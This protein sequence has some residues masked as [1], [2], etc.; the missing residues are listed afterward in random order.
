M[1]TIQKYGDHKSPFKVL[2]GRI[3]YT[4][5]LIEE[6]KDRAERYINRHDNEER[7]WDM[8]L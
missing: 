8:R 5:Y 7:F 2:F 4:D 1:V 6:D 3:G